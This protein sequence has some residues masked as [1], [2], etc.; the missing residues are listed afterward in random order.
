MSD[1]ELVQ[2]LKQRFEANRNRHKDIDWKE[3]TARL[4][5]KP[6]KL[7]SLHKMENTGGE[8]DVIER[9]DATG[10]CVFC[11]CSAESPEGR[12]NVCYDGK[13]E[14]E[15]NKKGVYP[16]G[17]AVDQAAEMGIELLSE[18]QYKKLQE[19]GH[20]MRRRQ[21]DTNT[22]RYS[23]AGRRFICRFSLWT[24]FLLPQQR[25]FLL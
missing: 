15:R 7:R 3:V 18:A 11:D 24:R 20:L 2:I 1:E 6:D 23:E 8:P 21:L 13:G 9:D 25:P 10:E 4:T 17:N 22:V 19:L 16:K 5:D 14:A 12:R